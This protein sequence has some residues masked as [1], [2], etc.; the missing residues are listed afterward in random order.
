MH[1]FVIYAW[2]FKENIASLSYVDLNLIYFMIQ[3]NQKFTFV[4]ITTSLI[5]ETS[6]RTEDSIKLTET[7]TSF[8]KF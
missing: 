6:L 1:D 3:K 4:D 2:S 8:Q 5:A 7:D